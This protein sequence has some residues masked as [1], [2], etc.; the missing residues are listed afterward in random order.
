MAI[1]RMADTP[2]VVTAGYKDLLELYPDAKNGPVLRLPQ[3]GFEPH[4]TYS[5]IGEK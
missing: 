2:M 4:W 1:V 5:E 3:A